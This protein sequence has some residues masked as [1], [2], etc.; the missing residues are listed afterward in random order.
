ML[1]LGSDRYKITYILGA[2]ASAKALPTV[3]ATSVSPGY[4]NALRQMADRLKMEPLIAGFVATRDTFVKD[5][6]WLAENGD[7]HGTP[8]TY[9]RFC[10]LKGDYFSLA[11]IKRTLSLY[12]TIEQFLEKKRDPRYQQFLIRILEYSQLFPEN[13][14][15]LNWNY[16]YQFQLAAEDFKNEEFHVG[17]G[18]NVH[19][20]PLISYYPALGQEFNVN[21][22]KD[23]SN[24][25]LIHLNGIAGFYY[26]VQTAHILSYFFNNS[27]SDINSLFEKHETDI[28]NKAPLLSFSF[29]SA[30]NMNNAIRNR[31]L[32][33]D[34]VAENTDYLVVIGYSFP[35]DNLQTDARILNTMKSGCLKEIFFQDPYNDGSFLRDTFS[36]PNEIP[37]THISNADEFYI[38]RQAK[39]KKL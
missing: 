8:D 3:R 36:I 37:I 18:A 12:F 2:G 4:T 34:K 38:P 30:N 7:Q 23:K 13:I 28:Q 1:D 25:Y 19:S 17:T 9:A 21:Y 32:Y 27:L 39:L 14:K 22:E 5:L 31:V 10:Q 20:P 24:Y 33:A 11:R 26:Y 15:I 16:D 6:Y 35:H 29:E